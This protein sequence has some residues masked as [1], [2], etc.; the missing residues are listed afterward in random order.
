MEYIMENYKYSSKNLFKVA[1]ERTVSSYL[2]KGV[3]VKINVHGISGY[4][5]EIKDSF[6]KGLE[7]KDGEK[8]EDIVTLENY[9]QK[10][11]PLIPSFNRRWDHVNRYSVYVKY[12]KDDFQ[13]INKFLGSFRITGYGSF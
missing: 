6:L 2:E 7:A 3:E 1:F 4:K 8:P 13:I 12:L 10:I 11:I 5:N 9:K